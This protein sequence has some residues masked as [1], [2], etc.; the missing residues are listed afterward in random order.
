MLFWKRKVEYPKKFTRILFATDIH[1]SETT[2]MKF[3]NAGKLYKADVLILGGDITG[4]LG[5]PIVKQADGSY[6]ANLGGVD[7][8]L[9][10]K[11]ELEEFEKEVLLL[12]FYPYLTNEVEM[13]MLREDQTKQREVLNRLIIERLEKWIKIA[14][15]RLKPT[16]IKIYVT[17]GNDDPFIIEDV[18]KK[19]S[20]VIYP[21]GDVVFIDDD[22][23]MIS[24]GYGNITPWNCPRDISEEKLEEI[25]E[26][27][28]SKVENMQNCIFNFHVPPINSNLDVC[29][30]LDVSVKPPKPIPGK[31]IAAGSTAVRN[32]IEKYQPLLGLHGHIHES[33]GAVYIGRTFCVNPGSEY[34]EGILRGVIINL[35]KD[36]IKSY[37]FVSG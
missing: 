22:H 35:E 12:G 11:L 30:M 8:I 15:E 20:Y 34:G 36:K 6:R 4:K 2:F 1:G 3:I 23:E 5:I 17:G 13:D 16:G 28:I 24:T 25:I 27:M 31:E 33:R 9:K 32:A 10:T 37:Q 19:S 29:P 26:G 7:R 21:E 18:L 14:E